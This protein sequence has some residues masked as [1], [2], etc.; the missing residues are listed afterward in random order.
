MKL[1]GIGLIIFGV[2][3]LVY[4]GFTIA[5]P[6]DTLDLGSF[7]ITTRENRT[8]PLPPI[9]GGISLAFGVLLVLLSGRR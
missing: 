9:V 3:A 7:T 2:L 1:L 6:K 4:H 8:I 5:I